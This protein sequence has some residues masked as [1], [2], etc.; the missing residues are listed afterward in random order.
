MG[1]RYILHP[2]LYIPQT[3]S[4]TATVFGLDMH[5]KQQLSEKVNPSFLVKSLTQSTNSKR[6]GGWTVAPGLAGLDWALQEEK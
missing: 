4:Y 3:C 2:S 5:T 6:A 1:A